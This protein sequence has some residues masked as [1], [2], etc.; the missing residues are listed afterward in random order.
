MLHK[1]LKIAGLFILM[2]VYMASNAYANEITAINFNGDIIGTVI[3]DGS[4]IGKQNDIIGKVTA[5]SFIVNNNNEII[6]GVVPQGIAIGND[7]K[8]LGKVN[9][10]GT[11]R[12]PTGKIIGKTL[13]NALV[14]DDSYNIIGAVLYPG[15]IYNNEGDT[16]GRLTGDGLYVSIEGQNIGFVSAMGYAYKNTG[17]DYVLDGKLVSSKMVVSLTGEFIGSVAPGGK[18]TDFDAKVIGSVHA[19]GYVYNKDNQ[20]VGKVITGGYAID[21]YGKYL[22]FIS[23][24]GEVINKGETVGRLRADNK[25]IDTKGKV[26]GYFIEISATA[27]DFNG[28]YLGRVI[29]DGKIVKTTDVIGSVGARG[30]VYNIDGAP[31]GEVT[32]AGPVFDYLGNLSAIALRSGSAVSTKG[33]LVGYVKGQYVFD[34]IGRMLGAGMEPMQIINLSDTILGM[35]FIGADFNK[36]N[37]YNCRYDEDINAVGI[38][39]AIDAGEEVKKLDLDLII[40]SPMIRTKH[41]CEIINVNNVP[42]IYDD[43]LMERIGGILTNTVIDDYYYTDYYNY[44]SSNIVDGLESLPDLFNRVHL[45]L[46]EI[47]KKYKDNNILL[48]THGAVARAIQFYFESMP[49]DGMLLNVS[50]QKNCEIRKYEI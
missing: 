50:G 31:I 21:T 19:N 26:I 44:Y 11:V 41:T 30:I 16:I 10:D 36:E 34:N 35:N 1:T 9:N 6:G 20:I 29:P 40:C 39:Q 27:T 48:V 28:K 15:L 18:V 49:D 37:K 7:N 8:F 3:P 2:T 17:T 38:K 23:Y 46:D 5:D 14:V 24:N 4:V 13:P 25:I 42:V 45:F 33:T 22:G 12:L 32:Y 43:R 47:I